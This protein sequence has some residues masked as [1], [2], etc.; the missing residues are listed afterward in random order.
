[1]KNSH[2]EEGGNRYVNAHYCSATRI[3]LG[4][5]RASLRT[6]AGRGGGAGRSRRQRGACPIALLEELDV[7]DLEVRSVEVR[8]VL[9]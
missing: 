1:M 4:L 8:R 2:R 5:R 7:R 6:S 3:R 9:Y